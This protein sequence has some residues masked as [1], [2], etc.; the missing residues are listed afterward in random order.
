MTVTAHQPGT[1]EPENPRTSPHILVVGLNHRSAPVEFRER[2]AF[3]REQLADAFARLRTEVGLREAAILSTCNR[4]EIY[5]SV[6][7]LGGTVDRLHRFLSEHGGVELHGLSA[8]LYT[9]TEPQSVQHLFAVASGVDSMVLG[10]GEILHQVKHAYEWAKDHGATGKVLHVLFQRA[11]NAAKAVRSQTAIGRGHTSV[12]SVAIELAEKIFGGFSRATVLL[13]G[14]G[15]IGAL[16]LKRL[17]ARGVGEVRIMNRSSE[18]AV[19]LAGEHGVDLLPLERLATQLEQVDIVISATSASGYLLQRPQ[20]AAAMH[21]RHQRPLCLVDLGVPRNVDP[22]VGTLENVY[23]F[24][25]DDLQGLV[26]HSHQERQAA[27][28]ESQGILERKA[29]RFL[30]WWRLECR[31]ASDECSVEHQGMTSGGVSHPAPAARP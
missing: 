19:R 8:K 21:A 24:D 18:R 25:V 31:V 12:G 30:E 20:V 2:L 7:E 29:D 15:E 28:G 13:I 1:R 3:R 9:Y 16:T 22:A 17:A 6:P 26:N 11:L 23:R 14:A 27:L 5:G 4:V 10:E